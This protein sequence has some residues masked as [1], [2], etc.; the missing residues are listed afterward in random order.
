MFRTR[1]PLDLPLLDQIVSLSMTF[2]SKRIEIFIVDFLLQKTIDSR[3]LTLL[4]QIFCSSVKQNITI[5][6]LAVKLRNRFLYTA[7]ESSTFD[8]KLQS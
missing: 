6:I 8:A 1:K 2:E 4:L 5:P 3:T 7:G